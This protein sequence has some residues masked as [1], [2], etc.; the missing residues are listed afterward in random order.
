MWFRNIL[1]AEAFAAVLVKKGCHNLRV[2]FSAKRDLTMAWLVTW[3]EPHQPNLTGTVVKISAAD[4]SLIIE[5][6]YAM[7]VLNDR[8]GVV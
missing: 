5:E 4:R 1:D 2:S 8:M 7:G 6:L 3:L